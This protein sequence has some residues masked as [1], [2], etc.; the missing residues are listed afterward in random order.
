[1]GG[2]GLTHPVTCLGDR[3]KVQSLRC[4]AVCRGGGTKGHA[5]GPGTPPG[6][7]LG[8]Q[9]WSTQGSVAWC[10]QT[11]PC[12]LDAVHWLPWVTAMYTVQLQWH[13]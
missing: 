3:Y 8:W 1:M 4:V 10:A 11:S 7:L 9:E 12:L 5:T 2:Q 13:R 6:L